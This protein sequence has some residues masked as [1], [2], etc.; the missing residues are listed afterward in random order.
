MRPKCFHP[1][2]LIPVAITLTGC[3]GL[4]MQHSI[5]PASFLLPGLIQAT[6]PAAPDADGV[7]VTEPQDPVAQVK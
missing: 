1:L 2:L 6:P 3:G 4:R 7:P 5:S